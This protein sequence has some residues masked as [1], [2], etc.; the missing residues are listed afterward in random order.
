MKFKNLSLSVT[1]PENFSTSDAMRVESVLLSVTKGLGYSGN[2]SYM[3]YED[4]M[5]TKPA[6][7]MESKKS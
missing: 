3:I 5:V 4:Y 7:D 6:A 1:L 2:V